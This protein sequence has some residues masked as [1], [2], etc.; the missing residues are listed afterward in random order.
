MRRPATF[1]EKMHWRLRHDRRPLLIGTC[2]KLAMKDR[3][4]RLAPGIVR[5]PETCWFGTDVAELAQVSLPPH[6]VLKPNDASGLVLFG[7]G[8]ARPDELA[9]RI[10]CWVHRKDR[11]QHEEWAYRQARPGLLVE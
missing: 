3:A 10:E 9:E 6:W 8:P 11:R 5:I 2:D 7:H 4:L 1:T